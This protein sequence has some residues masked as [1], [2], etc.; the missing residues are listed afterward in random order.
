[1]KRRKKMKGQF[2][3]TNMSRAARQA[4]RFNGLATVGRYEIVNHASIRDYQT[5]ADLLDIVVIRA[6]SP[7]GIKVVDIT[8]GD[9]YMMEVEYRDAPMA[10]IS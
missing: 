10:R 1:M 7:A 3:A 9:I 4:A 5:D 8:A 6:Y 2:R